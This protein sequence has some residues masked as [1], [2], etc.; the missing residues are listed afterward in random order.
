MPRFTFFFDVNFTSRTGKILAVIMDTI[1]F[2]Q[3]GSV[4]YLSFITNKYF[5]NILLN[6]T[7]DPREIVL[8]SNRQ[9]G[10]YFFD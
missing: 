8:V 4:F 2:M 10:D 1:L 9:N 5:R 3:H 7:N 6:K